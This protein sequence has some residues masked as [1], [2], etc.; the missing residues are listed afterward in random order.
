M[1]RWF[2]RRRA[3]ARIT[4][5]RTLSYCVDLPPKY[6]RGFRVLE[7]AR[8]NKWHDATLPWRVNEKTIKVEE[9]TWT[10]PRRIRIR[11]RIRVV[12]AKS[13]RPGRGRKVP[14]GL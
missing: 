9:P 8:Y 5:A 10:I 7:P 11:D 2:K 13:I 1:A 12:L 6:K 4:K 3:K 14:W